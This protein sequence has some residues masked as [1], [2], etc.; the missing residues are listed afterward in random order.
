[1]PFDLR[2]FSSQAIDGLVKNN[3][4]SF[5]PKTKRKV[6]QKSESLYKVYITK[7]SFGNTISKYLNFENLLL[8]K[9]LKRNKK[10]E[11]SHKETGIPEFDC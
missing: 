5:H 4:L 9:Q 1:M 10:K 6:Q 8:R 3:S 2:I 11:N 7:K